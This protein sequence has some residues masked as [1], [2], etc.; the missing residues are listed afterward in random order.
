MPG[1]APQ[2]EMQLSNST[3]HWLEDG[4]QAV[5]GRLTEPGS[6]P[7]YDP[8]AP[9]AGRKRAVFVVVGSGLLALIVAGYFFNKAQQH[10][11]AEPPTAAVVEPA[12]DLTNRAEAA[13]A[14]NKLDEALEVAHLALV[15]DARFA[16]AHFVVA[17]V[18]Q[19]RGE[20]GP[21]RDAY[22]KYLDLAPLGTHAAARTRRARRAAA[23]TT[24]GS[25]RRQVARVISRD[26][27]L[28]LADLK[29]RYVDRGRALPSAIEAALVADPRSG[30]RA[31][32]AAVARRRRANRS[33]GQRLRKMLRYET[34]LWTAGVS[35][36]AGVD[37][38]GMSPLAGPVAAAAVIFASGT[39][40]PD[41]DDSKRLTAEER[42][43]LAPVIRER[44]LAWS[45]AYAEVDEIDC[46]NIYWA[47][48]AAMRRAIEA[49]APAAEHLLIDG[50]KLRDVALPPAGHH[51]GRHQEPVD[52]RGVDPGQDVTRRPD[53]RLRGPVPGIRLRPAQGVPRRRPPAG[54]PPPRGLPYSPALV[55]HRSRGSRPAAAA[56]L[57]SAGGCGSDGPPSRRFESGTE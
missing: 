2:E 32:L 29:A 36:V 11:A 40:I 35:Y 12:R 55:R 18:K 39:R 28:P 20:G 14:A 1:T 37:E 25:R 5:P 33:E 42:E 23:V 38:A 13:L 15:A 21:A 16:D 10:R 34:T 4:D 9:V 54:Y 26:S 41:V 49:L 30:A 7:S 45:V 3:L 56:A 44:A 48:L 22:R 43:R 6:M 46:I 31:I 24:S 19:A 52:R 53:A 57:A 27:R 51:Q 47:G 50:R 17:S 8:R